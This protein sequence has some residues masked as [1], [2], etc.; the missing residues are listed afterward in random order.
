MSIRDVAQMPPLPPRHIKS[1]LRAIAS[2][3]LGGV[4]AVEAAGATRATGVSMVVE[5][6]SF[7]K[8]ELDHSMAATVG[9]GTTPAAVEAAWAAGAAGAA[10]ATGPGPGPSPTASVSP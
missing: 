6:A 8:R 7:P 10:R 1:L 3:R 9:T 4:H 5:F 2:L